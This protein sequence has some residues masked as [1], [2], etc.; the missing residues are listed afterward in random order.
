MA[1]CI[2]DT[3]S[4]TDQELCRMHCQRPEGS[5][6]GP[7]LYEWAGTREGEQDHERSFGSRIRT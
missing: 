1:L 5:C 6:E 7:T 2:Y 4:G 3:S